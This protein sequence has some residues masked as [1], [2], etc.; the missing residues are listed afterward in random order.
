MSTAPAAARPIT[1][2][3][4]Y[5]PVVPTRAATSGGIV[6]PAGSAGVIVHCHRDGVGFEVAFIRPAF[7]VITLTGDDLT[8]A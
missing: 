2:L 5:T 4:E 6:F 8:R 3:V 1:D 7:H